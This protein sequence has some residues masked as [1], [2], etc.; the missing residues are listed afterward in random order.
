MSIALFLMPST[1]IGEN[2]NI[3]KIMLK[4]FWNFR[5]NRSNLGSKSSLFQRHKAIKALK[6]ALPEG[7]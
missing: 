7:N 1:R 4:C 5:Q 2:F 3:A 6:Q